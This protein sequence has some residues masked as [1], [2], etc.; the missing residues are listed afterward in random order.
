[1]G[2]PFSAADQKDLPPPPDHAYAAVFS[3][4]L[5]LKLGKD[6]VESLFI[7]FQREGGLS[8]TVF[9]RHIPPGKPLL[10]QSS[11][12]ESR[13]FL[14]T[15]LAGGPCRDTSAPIVEDSKGDRGDEDG[16]T[17]EDQDDL[18]EGQCLLSFPSRSLLTGAP[19]RRF[20]RPFFGLGSGGTTSC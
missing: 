17:G 9:P 10:K 7:G 3:R 6:F 5:S 18:P 16:D 15:G 1:M 14:L 2:R 20:P 13:D 12:D 8:G 11:Q 19:G 4:Q